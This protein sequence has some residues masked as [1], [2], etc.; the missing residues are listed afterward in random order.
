MDINDFLKTY[1][2]TSLQA[3]CI[4]KSLKKEVVKLS[5]KVENISEQE[6][7]SRLNQEIENVENQIKNQLKF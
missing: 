1:A 7:L 6:A 2:A 5:A 4:A 3:L